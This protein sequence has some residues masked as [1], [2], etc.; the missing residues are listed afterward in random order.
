[1]SAEQMGEEPSKEEIETFTRQKALAIKIAKEA[2]KRANIPVDSPA[3][4]QGTNLRWNSFYQETDGNIVL[5]V[6]LNP[7][8]TRAIIHSA[9]GQPVLE[10]LRDLENLLSDSEA[11]QFFDVSEEERDEVIF[12]RLVGMTI[13]YISYLPIV[14]YHSFYQATG[15]AIINHIKKIVEPLYRM[16]ADSK[17]GAM[18][19]NIIPN[20]SLMDIVKRFPKVDFALLNYLEIID[21]EFTEHRKAVRLNRQVFLTPDRNENLY[22]EYDDLRIKFKEI[23]KE[24]KLRRP[25]YFM[26]HPTKGDADWDQHWE[27][28]LEEAFPS[29]TFSQ[30]DKE[31]TPSELAYRYLASQ[32]DYHP[33]TMERKVFESRSIAKERSKRSKTG[34]W[35]R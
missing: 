1:M 27:A 13:S 33:D 23:K 3:E 31:R 16:E 7:L 17:S 29:L 6:E 15:E 18:P 2:L 19:L 25:A 26:T 8:T 14:L 28:Y 12:E 5:S 34:S 21:K 35:K 24:F 30:N 10:M 22:L 9:L 11:I 32:F 20:N 4:Y